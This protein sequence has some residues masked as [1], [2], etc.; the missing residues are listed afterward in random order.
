MTPRRAASWAIGLG[1]SRGLCGPS[2]TV[3]T[4]RPGR[5]P[6]RS[7]EAPHP[8]VDTR[9]VVVHSGPRRQCV[10]FADSDE[11]KQTD[12]IQR[13]LVFTAVLRQ[14]LGCCRAGT[15][16]P[17]CCGERRMTSDIKNLSKLICEPQNYILGLSF[18][19]KVPSDPQNG[20]DVIR[21]ISPALELNVQ[22]WPRPPSAAEADLHRDL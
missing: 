2:V 8:A 17:V 13:R 1:S 7:Q 20:A 9:P 22:I 4:R 6:G 5:R 18:K 3:C 12:L 15:V 10:A 14:Q 19:Q 21:H 11:M 16:V